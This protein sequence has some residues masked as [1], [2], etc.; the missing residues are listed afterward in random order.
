MRKPRSLFAF[1]I[2]RGTDGCWELRMLE[3]LCELPKKGLANSRQFFN[4]L[5]LA[6][7]EPP[8]SVIPG[9]PPA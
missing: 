9:P 8:G 3:K 2:G 6:L 1:P 4:G 7:A 5:T